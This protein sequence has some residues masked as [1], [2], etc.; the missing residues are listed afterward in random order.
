MFL[1]T[2]PLIFSIFGAQV[3]AYTSNHTGIISEKCF[4]DLTKW[5]TSYTELSAELLECSKLANPETC[6]IFKKQLF[7]DNVYAIYQFDSFG[8]IPS[9]LLNFNKI[10]MGDY[11]ECLEVQN[12]TDSAY[13]TQFCW[14]HLNLPVGKLLARGES[15]MSMLSNTCG[16]HKPADVKSSICMPKSCSEMDIQHYLND[17]HHPFGFNQTPVCEVTCRPTEHPADPLFWLMT[18]I[19]VIISSL[20]I[21][22]TIADH[23]ENPSTSKSSQSNALKYFFAFSFLSNGRQLLHISKNPNTLK[24]VECI[25]FLSFTWVVAGHTWGYW[26]MADN[27]KKVVEIFKTREYEVWINAFLSVDTFFFLSGLML[28]Y[29]FLPKLSMRK[30]MSPMTWIVFYIHRILRLT[31]AYAFYILFY[32]TYGPLTDVGPHELVRSEDMQNCRKYFWKNLL[33]V[34]NVIEPRKACLSISWYLACDTQM[35]LVAPIFLVAFLIGPTIGILT[36]FLALFASTALTYFLFLRYDLPATLLQAFMSSDIKIIHLIQDLV[37][38]ASYIRIPPFLFGMVMGYVLWKTRDRK[39][40]INIGVTFFMWMLAKILAIGAIFSIYSYNKG[41]KWTSMERATYY[42]FSRIAWSFSLSWL[43]FAINRGHSG[44]IG[45]FMGLKF[46]TPLGKLTFCAYL[47]HMMILG[48]YFNWDRAPPHFN[49]AFY[50]YF[51]IIVPCVFGSILF[52]TCWTLLFEMPFAKLEG[53]FMQFLMGGSG[54]RK[55]SIEKT[56]ITKI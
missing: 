4:S 37:Y 11:D 24:G 18:A 20:C 36:S 31:P 33:Y 44:L 54:A 56:E 40:D 30:A 22:S 27:P 12:P 49:G 25:R 45:R 29:S 9:N 42:A 7:H 26:E 23:Y 3:Q 5:R 10:W 39:I 55:S 34:N 38:S 6:D 14:A 17:F 52:A 32:T 50:T 21:F 1:K 53:Y 51:S 28:A 13:S 15:S 16:K 47:C 19:L 46:W 48:A 41:E 35:Y 43:I 2:L 8:K